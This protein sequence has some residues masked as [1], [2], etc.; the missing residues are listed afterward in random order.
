LIDSAEVLVTSFN[1]PTIE[2]QR[3][4][5][6]NPPL[7]PPHPSSSLCFSIEKRRPIF[8]ASSDAKPIPGRISTHFVKFLASHCLQLV[9]VNPRVNPGPPFLPPSP[10]GRRPSDIPPQIA[11]ERVPAANMRTPVQDVPRKSKKQ[12]SNCCWTAL[13]I[14]VN[15]LVRLIPEVLG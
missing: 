11:R 13:Q 7:F 10:S 4:P 5:V 6:A 12:S 1:L 3:N 8:S 2:T 14:L 15:N 9:R